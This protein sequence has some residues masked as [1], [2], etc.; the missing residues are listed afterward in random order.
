VSGQ[1]EAAGLF[2]VPLSTLA[3]WTRA[4]RIRAYRTPGGHRRYRES[5]VRTLITDVMAE[6]AA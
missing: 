4:G 1:F 6:A 5:D 3:D 2:R